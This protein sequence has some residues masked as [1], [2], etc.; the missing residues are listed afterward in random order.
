MI[1][2]LNESELEEATINDE[3]KKDTAEAKKELGAEVYSGEGSIE[4]SLN[5]ALKVSK[6]MQKLGDTGDYPNLLFIGEAGTGKTSRIRAWARKN[7]VNLF[8]VRAAGMDDTDLGGAMTPMGDV[9]KRLASTGA[10]T[11]NISLLM[12]LNLYIDFVYVFIRIVS[13]IGNSRN[14]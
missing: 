1:I 10:L 3:L 7:N 14:N 2:K 9:V 8:E 13:L 11:T 5:R 6:R 12:A 4:T